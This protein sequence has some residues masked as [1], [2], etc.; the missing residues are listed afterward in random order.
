[1][2]RQLRILGGLH[3][4]AE[5]TLAREQR[6]VIGS[7]ADC[8]IVLFDAQVAPR[9]C[10]IQSDDFGLSC[11]ALDAAVT[12][13]RADGERELAPG[14]VA[15]LDDFTPVRCGQAAL[16]VGPAT[17]EWSVAEHALQAPKQKSLHAVRS[18][19]QLNPYALFAT[20]MLGITSVIGLAYAA[21]S[22]RTYEVTADEVVAARGWLKSVAPPDSELAIGA[23][24]L[25]GQP[26]LLTG[27]VRTEQQLQALLT[28]SRRSGFAPSV[29]VYAVEEMTVAM[30]RLSRLSQLPCEP[31]YQGAGQFTC[32]DPVPNEIV[33][34][35]LRMV[36][37]DVPGL[38][39]L[40]VAVLP[41]PVVAAAPAPVPEAP[42]DPVRLTRKFSVLMWRNQ[43]YLIGQYGERYKEGEQFDG[44]TINRIGVDKILF[45][46]D[47]RQFEF[48]VAALSG[49]RS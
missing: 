28:A 7:S 3:R 10:V 13:V 24:T 25:P 31:R 44:F 29:E 46:R 18:L 11:R 22:D 42:S 19:R 2:S 15:K 1:M 26:L 5:V 38:R 49:P 14:E 8:S 20:V 40:H 43:R 16:S 41:P 27:Y 34:G 21:L 6:C 39:G 48:Y 35:K 30:E 37:R 47:G 9:H 32:A 23:S 12:L 4:G 33:A 17:G 45:E 36:A